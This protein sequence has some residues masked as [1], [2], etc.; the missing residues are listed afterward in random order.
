[1]E[2]MIGYIFG[3]LKNNDDAIKEIGKH[4]RKQSRLNSQFAICGLATTVWLYLVDKRLIGEKKNLE[5]RLEKMEAEIKELK[6]LKGE[7]QM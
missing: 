6:T 5:Q 1:M 3:S 2:K 7:Q 4:L